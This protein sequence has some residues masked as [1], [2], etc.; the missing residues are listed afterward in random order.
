MAKAAVKKLPASA[1][2]HNSDSITITGPTDASNSSTGSSSVSPISPI[3]LPILPTGDSIPSPDYLATRKSSI[4][5]QS[6][7]AIGTS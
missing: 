2:S 6:K 7:L 3:N 4:N 1:L 5:V